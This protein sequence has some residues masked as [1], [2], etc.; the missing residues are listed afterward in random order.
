MDKSVLV[1]FCIRLSLFSVD[2]E[3]IIN[4]TTVLWVQSREKSH[5]TKYLT[6]STDTILCVSPNQVC[7]MRSWMN[8]TSTEILAWPA[9]PSNMNKTL[10]TTLGLGK[11]SS[12]VG[13]SQLACNHHP[14]SGCDWPQK[15]IFGNN[16]WNI[17]LLQPHYGPTAGN[18]ILL[19]WEGQVGQ[20][21]KI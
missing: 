18:K 5:L 17:N 4:I 7:R 21:R 2:S 9:R 6:G 13:Q 8:V 11:A 19:R 15:N 20:A 1:G 12:S 10:L 16:W 3:Q 14:P